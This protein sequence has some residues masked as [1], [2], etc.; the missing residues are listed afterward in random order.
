MYW[1]LQSAAE[2][3]ME[4]KRRRLVALNMLFRAQYGD[5]D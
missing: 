4:C 1:N 2:S 3:A 5:M